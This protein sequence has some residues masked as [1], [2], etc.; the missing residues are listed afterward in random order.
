[1]ALGA[2]FL[3]DATAAIIFDRHVRRFMGSARH[4]SFASKSAQA[5]GKTVRGHFLFLYDILVCRSQPRRRLH[6]PYGLF[7]KSAPY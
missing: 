4:A 3:N 6:C 5:L 7:L 2:R 1:M